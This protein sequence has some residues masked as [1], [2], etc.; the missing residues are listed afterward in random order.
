M[1]NNIM[2]KGGSRMEKKIMMTAR[3]IMNELSVSESFAYGLIR[4]FNAELKEKGYTII[5]GRISRKY[6][7]EQFYGMAENN[8]KGA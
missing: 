2:T 5:R 1:E 8:N 3:D 6:F 4:K 7:E